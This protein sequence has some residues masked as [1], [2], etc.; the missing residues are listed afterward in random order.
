[1]TFT[2]D[3]TTELTA[4]ELVAMNADFSDRIATLDGGL[5]DYASRVAIFNEMAGNTVIAECSPA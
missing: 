1:M 2:A 3:N 4:D 5:V